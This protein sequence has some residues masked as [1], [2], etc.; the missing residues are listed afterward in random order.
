MAL[1]RLPLV[2]LPIA[3]LIVSTP[4]L[5]DDV[6]GPGTTEDDSGEADDDTDDEDDKGCATAAAPISAVS[7]ALGVGLVLLQRRR[8]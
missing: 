4:A 6:G 8:N 5:A 1:R 2:L 3:G 7:L